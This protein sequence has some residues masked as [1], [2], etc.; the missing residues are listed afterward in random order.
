MAAKPI[1]SPAQIEFFKEQGYL[2][3][4]DFIDPDTVVGWR[5]QIWRHL[6]ASLEE[7]DQW[8]DDY[9][10]EGFSHEP[11]FGHMPQMAA[12][13]EQLGGGKF[14]GGGSGPLVKWPQA[15]ENWSMPEQGHIDGYG[16]NGWSGGFMLGATTYLYDVE[17][18]GG[19]FVYW[20]ASHKP[21]HDFFCRHPEKIDGSFRQGDDW[22]ARSWGIFS[23]DAP[24]EP[25]QFSARAGT[26]VLWHCYMCHTGSGNIGPVP[27][28]GFF[29]RWHH[30]DREEMRWDVAGDLWKHWAI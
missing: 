29:A 28:F 4:E 12:A 18:G 8:P 3:L 27:R 15:G 25:R 7:P 5:E 14:T 23:D 30:V 17:P 16:P 24:H 21:V 10:V 26:V 9:V 2:I 6:G 19:A 20:P 11:V 13:V 1:L 22:E